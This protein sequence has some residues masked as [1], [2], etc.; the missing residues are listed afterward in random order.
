MTLPA[1]IVL[2]A[3]HWLQAAVDRIRRAFLTGHAAGTAA[4]IGPKTCGAT[5]ITEFHGSNTGPATG[6]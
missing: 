5:R 2:L 3:A 6:V 4:T 1:F